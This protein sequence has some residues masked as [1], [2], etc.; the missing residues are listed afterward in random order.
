MR[1]YTSL[2]MRECTELRT[3]PDEVRLGVGNP[4]RTALSASA[5]CI[6]A[7]SIIRIEW[8]WLRNQS[9]EILRK[10]QSRSSTSASD[11][12]I[13]YN[14]NNNTCDLQLNLLSSTQNSELGLLRRI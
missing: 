13:S 9:S 12:N 11:T 2:K 1:E 10:K 8:E 7:G 3:I 4:S 5:L 14:N 6:D